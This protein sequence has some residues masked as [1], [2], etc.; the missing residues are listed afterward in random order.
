MTDQ[1]LKIETS[2]GCNEGCRCVAMDENY[3]RFDLFQNSLD[4]HIILNLVYDCTKSLRFYLNTVSINYKLIC[5]PPHHL[6]DNANVGLDYSHDFIGYIGVGVI[7]NW[8]TEVAVLNH[9]NSQIN[10]LEKTNCVNTREDKASFIQSFWTF[11]RCA[12]TDGRDRM[13]D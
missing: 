8:N 10:G 13:T 7:R 2:Q 4:S 5:F 11:S 6:I 12:D 3:I 1:N 9:L